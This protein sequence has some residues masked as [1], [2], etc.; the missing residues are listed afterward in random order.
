VAARGLWRRC[1]LTA[2]GWRGEDGRGKLGLPQE[3][4]DCHNI[5]CAVQG[6][7]TGGFWCAEKLGGR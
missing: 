5:H 4:F 6:G 2:E 3:K 1:G 7:A